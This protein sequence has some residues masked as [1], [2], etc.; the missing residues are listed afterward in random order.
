[1]RNIF[2]EKIVRIFARKADAF[3]GRFKPMKEILEAMRC[4][5]FELLLELTNLCNANCIFCPY[6]FQKREI[7]FMTDEVFCK[8]VH[9]FCEIGGGSVGLTPIVGDALLDPKFLERVRFLRAQP[10][11]DRIFMTT[12]GILLHKHGIADI[13]DSGLSSI[14][15]SVAGFNKNIYSS[16]YRCDSYQSMF[17][18]VL[19]LLKQNSIRN[20]PIAISIAMRPNCSLRKI[21]QDKDFKAVMRYN[22]VIDFAWSYTSAG[23]RI[24]KDMLPKSMKLRKLVNKK[25]SCV[26]LYNGP[27]I[28]PDGKVLACCCVPAVDAPSDLI[29]GNILK[30]HLLEIWQ[31]EQLQS[32]RNQFGTKSLN[33]TCCQCDMYRD[34]ELYRTREGRERAQT[35]HLRNEGKI[36]KRGI[37]ETSPFMGG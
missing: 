6:Q 34:L 8:A 10:N 33:Q 18:N 25:E 30:S 19:E 5:P 14:V 24:T 15:I 3:M 29:I 36:V 16:V 2:L 26:S 23:G 28:L 31:G 35:N 11:I 22:P 27:I 12:N 20:E 37:K 21:T 13:L 32:I 9:D 4:R 7:E 17:D 1:M